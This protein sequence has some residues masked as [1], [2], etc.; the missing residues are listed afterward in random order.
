[1]QN[2]QRKFVMILVCLTLF[3][4]CTNLT[5]SQ[6]HFSAPHNFPLRWYQGQLNHLAAVRRGE[7]PMHHSCSE[8]SL[9]AITRHGLVLGWIMT[10]DRL[11]R[12]GRDEM[13]FAQRI[14]TGGNWKY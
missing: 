10:T 3:Q 11:M 5:S 7:C 12:C 2:K 13:K 1:M 6:N 4:A 8:Y 9:Q 14:F